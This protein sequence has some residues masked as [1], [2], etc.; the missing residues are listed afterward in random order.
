[1]TTPT[2][3][4]N[5][6]TALNARLPR[7]PYSEGRDARQSGRPRHVCPYDSG[8]Y[9]RVKWLEGWGDEDRSEL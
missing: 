2:Q 6:L 1:M 8:T 4:S 7:Q 5:V 9:A 3:I